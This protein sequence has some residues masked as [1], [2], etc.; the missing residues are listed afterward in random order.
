MHDFGLLTLLP[1]LVVIVLATVT[2]SSFEPLVIGILTGCVIAYRGNFLNKFIEN[3]TSALT[4]R[5]SGWVIL[6][7]MLYGS[8]IMMMIRGGGTIGFSNFLLKFV[9]SRRTALLATW[10]LGLLIFVDDY[11]HSLAVGAAMKKITDQYRISRELLAYVIHATSAPLCILL[12]ISTWSIFISGILEKNKIVPEGQ[13]MVGY[14]HAMPYMIYGFVGITLVFTVVMGWTPIIGKMKAAELRAQGGVAIPPDPGKNVELLEGDG[15][16]AKKSRLIYF[17]LPLLVLVATTIYFDYDA[18]K[19]ALIAN[20][21]TFCLLF[22]DRAMTLRQLSDS[23]LRGFT[24][25][26]FPIVLVILAFA[27]KLVN[28]DLHLVPYVITHVQPYMSRETFPAIAF[29]TLAVIAFLTG[30]S[31][32]LYVIAIPLIIPLAQNLGANV[33]VAVSV[34]T[35]AGAFGSNTGFFSDSTIL[36]ASSTECPTM[37]HALTQLPYA[38]IALGGSVVVYLVVGMFA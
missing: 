34:V 8:L 31:W 14:M 24:T 30:S 6:V 33:W 37:V 35:C 12:P 9:H 7:C 5:T 25:I 19:G 18:L 4:D 38:L 28:D 22:F 32:D 10:I 23:I 29:F 26:L 11:L 2:R 16:L 13:G 21:F 27:L 17:V 1:V 36:S 20:F 15:P 3:L